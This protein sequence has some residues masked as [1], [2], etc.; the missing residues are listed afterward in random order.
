MIIV[1]CWVPTS[2]ALVTWSISEIIVSSGS[3]ILSSTEDLEDTFYLSND[4]P[5]EIELWKN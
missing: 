1:S 3:S 2:T 4:I 5:Y